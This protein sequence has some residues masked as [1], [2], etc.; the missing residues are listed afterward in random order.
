MNVSRLIRSLLLSSAVLLLPVGSLCSA[1]ETGIAE[2][3][4]LGERL[5]REGILPNGEP[6]QALVAGDIP[7]DG[8]MF[9]CVNCHQRSGLGSVEGSLITWPTTGKELYIPRRRTG[10]W[11]AA[12]AHKGPGAVE[13]WTLPPQY[14]AADARPAYTDESLA[15]LLREG[16]DPSGRVVSR[17][18]PRFDIDDADM[19]ILIDYLKGLSLA[20]DEGVDEQRIRFATVVSKGVPEKERRAMLDVLRAHIDA[21]NTQTRPYKRRATSGPFYKTEKFTAYRTFELDVWEL[22]G[23]PQS[24]GKQLENYYRQGPVFAMLGGI[25]E[26]SWEPVH[27]FCEERRIPCLFPVTDE[28]VISGTDWYTLYFSRGLSQE[29]ETAAQFLKKRYESREMPAILQ[30]YRENSKGA[31]AAA[32]FSRRWQDSKLQGIPLPAKGAAGEIADRLSQVSLDEDAILLLWLDADDLGAVLER[33]EPQQQQALPVI[34]SASLVG[35][36]NLAAIPPAFRQ[37]LFI[38]YPRSLPAESGTERMVLRR[39]LQARKIEETNLDIQAQMYFLGWALPGAVSYMR[40]EFY[41]D[42]FLEGFDMMRDQDY[43]IATFPR[44]S[45]GPGQ[46]YAAKGCYM[47]QLGDGDPPELIRRSPWVAH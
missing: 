18:M 21:H 5:Y 12:A 36:K 25:A 26:G 7:V 47:V 23:D 13:R 29:G 19:A 28:P 11:N 8:R 41:R 37:R 38:S 44:L 9:S 40:S 24:W 46:R 10:A 30:L 6:V 22:E 39:W 16:I 43:A 34:V 2:R 27:S 15:R 33:L 42:Y 17:A 32:G 1:D 45:F 4:A 31:L 3:R 14:R 35:E 20:I